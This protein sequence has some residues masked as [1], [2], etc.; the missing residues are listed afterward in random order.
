MSQGRGEGRIR[1]AG[2]GEKAGLDWRKHTARKSTHT[3]VLPP[4]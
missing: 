1:R 2:K 3:R 4:V